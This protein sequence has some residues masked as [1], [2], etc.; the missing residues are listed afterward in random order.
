M[1]LLINCSYKGE[2][3]NSNY[4]LSKLQEKLN[5]EYEHVHLQK[6]HDTN[7]IMNKI[8]EA[9]S[10]VF[11]MPLYADNIPAQVM[12]LMEKLYEEGKEKIG[13]TNIYVITNLGFYDSKEAHI[14][15]DI[16]R[17]WCTK[18]NIVYGGAIAIG[19]GEMLGGFKNISIDKGP[20]RSL[21]KGLK[22]M[23]DKIKNNESFDNMYIEPS[24]IPRW[25]YMF[26]ADR[27]WVSKAKKNGVGK[28]EILNRK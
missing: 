8:K 9:D 24:L 26:I 10:V 22:K 1:V 2:R 3:S 19:A 17:N 14:Q 23:A 28:K 20:N 18:M 25:M 16:V 12:E 6:I 27:L 11:A 4:F 15:L 13:N 21:G 7:L 5:V